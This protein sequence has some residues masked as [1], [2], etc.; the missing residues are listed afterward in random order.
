MPS[1]SRCRPRVSPLT[2]CLSSLCLISSLRRQCVSYVMHGT[3]KGLKEV[4]KFL[5]LT[6]FG[7]QAF[8]NKFFK[9]LFIRTR[10]IGLLYPPRQLYRVFTWNK[11]AVITMLGF[12]LKCKDG[13]SH[14]QSRDSVVIYL[15]ECYGYFDNDLINSNHNQA[16]ANLTGCSC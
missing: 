4:R 3:G 9:R 12:T 14:A 5:P 10:V 8:K 15:L 2:L 6:L 16:E 11:S 1:S 7:Y 13:E